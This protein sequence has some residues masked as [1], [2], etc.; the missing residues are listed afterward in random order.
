MNESS[1]PEKANLGF[2][3]ATSVVT[4]SM[5]GSG[6]FL[7]PASLANFGSISLGG[8][9]FTALGSLSLAYVFA[10]LS[11][12]IRGSGGQYLY[13]R[14]AFGPLAG[15]FTAWGY[16]LCVVSANAAITIAL[17]SYLTVFFPVL[18]S[19]NTLS[20][21]TTLGFIW[22]LALINIRGVKLAGK[23]QLFTTLL[24][25]LPLLAVAF[26]GLLYVNP[27]HFQPVNL[28]EQ[29][30]FSALTATAALTMW[31]F[32]GMEAANNI[33]G[34]IKSPEKNVPRAALLGTFISAIVY[35]LGFIAVLGIIPPEV[36]QQ[37]NAPYADTA[38]FLWGDIGY[39]LIAV[40]AVISC[41]GALNGWTLAVA[42]IP[43][44]A[45]KENMFLASF[46]KLSR[47]Q[48]PANGIIISTILVSILVLMNY[49]ESLI[50][51]FTIVILLSTLTS[52]L[53]YLVSSLAHIKM[54]GKNSVRY[55]LMNTSISA[56]AAVFS[57]WIIYSIGAKTV[58]MGIILL[59]A[60][61]PM[62][63][64][65]QRKTRREQSSQL[66]GSN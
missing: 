53:P 65:L 54:S 21:L 49:N 16:W 12:Y 43:L 22:G 66:P 23:V 26:I 7:L 35:I 64:Y 37:S 4:G 51:Q 24:K 39:Y 55:S 9:I 15:F 58:I 48:T 45:A 41:F 60:G 10:K 8:W 6:V 63:V 42:Q 31:A 38:A 30:D 62:Y 27:E 25:L 33:A 19:S 20:L 32:V 36:L 46:G 5:I 11:Q 52:V 61:F 2:W 1:P 50:E 34:E 14:Q 3:T 17:V 29:S 18:K 13:C 28:S 57:A 47:Y 59:A 44:A 40:C 56:F